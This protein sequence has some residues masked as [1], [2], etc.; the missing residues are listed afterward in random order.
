[1]ITT[2]PPE[3]LNVT[4][5]GQLSD[6]FG[7]E[8]VF[9]INARE[10]GVLMGRINDSRKDPDRHIEEVRIKAEELSG[11]KGPGNAI[12]PV[13]RGRY[14]RNGYAVEMYALHGNGN[15]IIPL[16]L[17]VPATGDRF[18]SVIYLH[19]GGKATDAAP[20]GRIEQLVRK[21]YLVAAPDLLGTGETAPEK[22]FYSSNYLIS[23]L[24]GQSVTGVQAGDI[25]SVVNFLKDRKDADRSKIAAMAFDELCPSLLHAAAFDRSIRSVALS[26]PL[27]SYR[28]IVMN[29]FYNSAFCRNYVAGAL[30]A[31]DLPDLIACLAPS[32]ISL[33]DVR[34]QMQ[35]PADR[36]IIDEEL[37]FPMNVYNRKNVP[38]NIRIMTSPQETGSVAGWL[39]GE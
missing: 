1:M 34:D 8:T 39:F 11:Y 29:R 28:S 22:S 30:T 26:G 6:S 13:F 10:A 25:V 27:I 12:N 5:T 33:V 18:P 14:Q 38:D 16:L 21:G 15:Y 17:F 4:P 3:E 37:K 20:G 23:V 2:L 31:Y 36:D 19:P 32:R 24:T 7:G 35:E 9:S